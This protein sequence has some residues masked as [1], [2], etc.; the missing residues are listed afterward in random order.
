[1]GRVP[2]ATKKCVKVN[3]TLF[4]RACNINHSTVKCKPNIVRTMLDILM[5]NISG[6][7]W[8]RSGIC[9]S[10]WLRGGINSSG[11]VV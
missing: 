3:C 5:G 11:W 8:F 4:G 10:R 6:L 2:V 7:E 9:K 1:M